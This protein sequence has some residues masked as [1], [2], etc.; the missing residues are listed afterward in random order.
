M[1][2]IGELPEYIRRADKLLTEAQRREVIDYLAR[3]P[4]AG[5]LL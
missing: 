4:K 5:D 3:H 1:L 2:T